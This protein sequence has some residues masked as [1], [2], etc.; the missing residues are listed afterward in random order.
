MDTIA[1]E[2]NITTISFLDFLKS[3]TNDS[4]LGFYKRIFNKIIPGIYIFFIL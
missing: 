1:D 2:F 4:D 3:L